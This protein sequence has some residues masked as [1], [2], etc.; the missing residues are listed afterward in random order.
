MENPEKR[1]KDSSDSGHSPSDDEKKVGL[2]PEAAREAKG[3]G[4][5]PPDPD[6]NLGEEEKAKIVRIAGFFMLFYHHPLRRRKK[7]L[8]LMYIRCAG[9]A[10]ALEA[11]PST[12][13]LALPSLPH[14]LP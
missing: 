3:Y 9:Q 6:A 2:E 1:D 4:Q 11:R 12:D 14:Q 5:L 13:S 7:R 10:I 8:W